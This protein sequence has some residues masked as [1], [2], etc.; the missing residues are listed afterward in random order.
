[1]RLEAI[2]VLLEHDADINLQLDSQRI[3]DETSLCGV[4]PGGC[5]S[6][7]GRR[8]SSY[9]NLLEYGADPNIPKIYNHE[10]STALQQASSLGS[11]EVARLLLSYGAKVDEKDEKG[12]TQFHVAT[13]ERRDEM[14]KLLT[15]HDA[16]PPSQLYCSVYSIRSRFSYPNIK[17]IIVAPDVS[18]WQSPSS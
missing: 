12:G 13:S 10:Y 9:S 16:V 18:I 8:S 2:Q 11:L 14:G 17:S 1:M 3:D 15:Q 4:L 6:P 7:E 5:S